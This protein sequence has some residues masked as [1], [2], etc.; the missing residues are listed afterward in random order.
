MDTCVFE[1]WLSEPRTMK[2]LSNSATRT[3]YLENVS[4]YEETDVANSAVQES[5]TDLDFLSKNTMDR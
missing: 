1:E 5:K 2:P 3:P 4:G